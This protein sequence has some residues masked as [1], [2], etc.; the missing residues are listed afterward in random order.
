MMPSISAAK[1]CYCDD[2]ASPRYREIRGWEEV[3]K[4]GGANK[5]TGREETGRYACDECIRAI[6]NGY[7]PG[8]AR[9]F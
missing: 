1:C 9:L 5:I 7:P 6:R 4:Q 3:R 2:P 8:H